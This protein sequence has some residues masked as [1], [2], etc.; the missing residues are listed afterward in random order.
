MLSAFD[1]CFQLKDGGYVFPMLLSEK[2]TFP[3]DIRPLFTQGQPGELLRAR[4]Y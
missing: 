4:R 1:I 3:D 2:A